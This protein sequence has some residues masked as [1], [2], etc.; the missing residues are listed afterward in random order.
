MLYRIYVEFI[1]QYAFLFIG[2]HSRQLWKFETATT[3]SRDNE[4]Y[5]NKM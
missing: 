3:R 4:N 1:N 2:Y 5:S